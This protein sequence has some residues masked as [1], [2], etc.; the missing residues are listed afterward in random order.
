MA[1]IEFTVD[2]EIKQEYLA[3]KP[4]G[5]ADSDAFVLRDFDNY[6]N[7]ISKS[8]YNLSI[9]E[10]NEMFATLRNTSKRG[11]GKNKSILVNY[12]DFCV[13][14]KIVSHMENRARY[15]DINDF[16]HRQA[17]LSK[18][19]PKEK[20]MQY[21]NMLYNA[22]DQLLLWLSYIGVRGRTIENATMEEIISLTIDDINEKNRTIKLWQ[23]GRKK[24]RI[25][26]NVPDFIFDL[27]RETYN[28]DYYIEN[29]G[30]VTNNP[31]I[32]DPRKSII[33][34][35]GESKTGATIDRYILRKPGKNKFEL[36]TPS[37]LNSRMRKIQEYCDNRYITYSSLFFSGM[38]QMA[39]DIYK[40][41]GEVTD[42]DFDDICVRYNYG[43]PEEPRADKRASNYWYVVKDLF[44]QYKEL[45]LK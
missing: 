19:I 23:N 16:V 10:L 7:Q 26:D 43:I 40:E 42:R 45:L 37:L 28:E 20:M 39:M 41:K 44:N 3:S 4:T 30:E 12:I 22:Q 32:P 2:N 11:A 35:T 36:F 8:V 38:L 21:G 27:I 33:N 14:K 15:I 25:L 1:N 31:R 6:E 18:Y 17:L 24:F 13:M 34:K 5:T 29:N 9:P